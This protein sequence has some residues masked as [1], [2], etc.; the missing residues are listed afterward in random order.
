M[1][2]RENG[3][4]GGLLQGPDV[5]RPSGRT[6]PWIVAFLVPSPLP[7]LSQLWGAISLAFHGLLVEI[8][9][10]LWT[11]RAGSVRGQG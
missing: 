4:A 11:P 2:L 7:P 6:G 5:E 10:A 3:G 8:R 9:A 1:M